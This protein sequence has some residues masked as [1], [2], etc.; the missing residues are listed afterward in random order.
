MQSQWPHLLALS[1]GHCFLLS[2]GSSMFGPKDAEEKQTTLLTAKF[3]P[4]TTVVTFFFHNRVFK[5]SS[6][7]AKWLGCIM[8]CTCPSPAKAH[9]WR[10][11]LLLFGLSY[12]WFID[13]LFLIRM[14]PTK[15]GC[16]YQWNSQYVGSITILFVELLLA[17]NHDSRVVVSP[18]QT[19]LRRKW[20]IR[21][22]W[23]IVSGSQLQNHQRL[24]NRKSEG[25][26]G[27][28]RRVKTPSRRRFAQVNGFVASPSDMPTCAAKREAAVAGSN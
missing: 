14:I 21:W 28:S 27:V 15:L 8:L 6:Q 24:F 22:S 2:L 20:V 19:S 17:S 9:P 5:K 3:K 25:F 4:I 18:L 13:Q 23:P 11:R 26:H 7:E 16:S 10:G 1:Q 12:H